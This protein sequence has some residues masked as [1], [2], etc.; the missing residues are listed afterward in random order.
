MSF[1][2]ELRRRNVFRVALFY[3]VAAWVVIQVAETLL[4]VFDVPDTAIRIIVLILALG[5]P[6]AVVFSWVFEMTPEGF[7]RDKDLHLDPETK[8]ETAHKLNWATLIAAVLAIGLLVADRLMPEAAP[9]AQS[10]A[11][12]QTSPASSNDETGVNVPDPASIA[13][14][15][16]ADL[17]PIGDQAYFSDGISEEILNV[18]AGIEGLKVASRTS[19]FLFKDQPQPIPVMARSL[20]VA[21]VLEGSVR[22]SGERIRITAQL[23]A[24]DSD[25]HL[26]SDT[27]DRELS[28]D[29]LFAI[30]DEIANA[31]V[32]ALG[33]A[34]DF[35]TRS[36]IAVAPSTEN[37]DAYELYLKARELFRDRSDLPEAFRLFE[38]AVDLDPGFARAWEGMAAVGAVI[39]DWGFVDRPYSELAAT[40]A[41]R[42]LELAPELSMPWA[43]R[44]M[45]ATLNR[46]IDFAE[47]LRLADRA[48]KA[49]PNNATALLWR[50]I[51]WLNLGFFERAIADQDRCLAIDPAY[52]NC[53]RFR[54]VSLQFMGRSDDALAV[55]VTG[56]EN[57]FIRNR[58]M[59]FIRP[60]LDRDQRAMAVLLMTA[61]QKKSQ[62]QQAMFEFH[63]TGHAPADARELVE[64]SEELINYHAM[65]YLV[66]GAYELA[67]ETPE[68]SEHTLVFWDP[69]LPGLRDSAAFKRILSRFGIPAYW[70]EYGY[71]PMCRPLDG[72]QREDDFECD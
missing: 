27:Y 29:N 44:S 54:A 23:I 25:A 49:D 39:E 28:A 37:L 22:K 20:G 55:F 16:F 38:Q 24:A 61:V 43:V 47:A 15:P 58:A 19:S 53:R 11:D 42:A 65:N 45:L 3:I 63:R 67:A 12:E 17:S 1:V 2:A 26:W 48:V 21:H 32:T 14:L 70:R 51:Y 10:V 57:G 8:R 36:R 6:L 30:Q 60:L 69:T 4:P 56:V 66:L 52:E 71:P 34:M 62:W 40:A 9:G 46:P 18:L 7:K 5:F 68:I 31:I 35:Q 13:V 50:S 33:R 41:D 72:D 59:S 64:G